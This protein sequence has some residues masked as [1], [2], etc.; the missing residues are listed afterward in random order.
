MDVKWIRSVSDL[1]ISRTSLHLILISSH[2]YTAGIRP[3][4]DIRCFTDISEKWTNWGYQMDTIQIF[5]VSIEWI[6]QNTFLFGEPLISTEYHYLTQTCNKRIITAIV[7]SEIRKL[8]LRVDLSCWKICEYLWSARK[9]IF[10]LIIVGYKDWQ[11]NSK[12]T[13]NIIINGR[14]TPVV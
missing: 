10:D 4:E 12:F 5:P 14:G 3:R 7:E 6:L 2:S 8:M 9:S 13:Y 11:H 1:E